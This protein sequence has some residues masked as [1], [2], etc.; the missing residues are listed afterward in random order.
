MCFKS[1]CIEKFIDNVYL[2]SLQPSIENGEANVKDIFD[3][4]FADKN[5]WIQVQLSTTNIWAAGSLMIQRTRRI[6]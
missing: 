2:V 5:L 1:T 4:K 3:G 6:Y